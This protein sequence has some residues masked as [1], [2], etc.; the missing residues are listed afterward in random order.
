MAHR[1]ALASAAIIVVLLLLALLAG[2]L[3]LPDPTAQGT[4][5]VTD[6]G[7]SAQHWLGT[8]SAGRDILS[9]LIYGLR[10]AFVAG[11]KP[12]ENIQA[13]TAAQAL[14][15][16]GLPPDRVAASWKRWVNR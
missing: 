1:P 14:D 5:V 6:A 16:A 3:P 2:L 4:D 9:R 11:F 12:E 8:D 15:A 7:P 10:P 13:K